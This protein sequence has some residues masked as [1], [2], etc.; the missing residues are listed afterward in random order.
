M[1]PEGQ[2]MKVLQR[3]VKTIDKTGNRSFSGNVIDDLVVL[4]CCI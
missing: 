3:Q 2:V 4:F 1:I